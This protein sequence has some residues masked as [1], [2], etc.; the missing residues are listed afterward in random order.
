VSE[1]KNKEIKM[2]TQ[3]QVNTLADPIIISKQEF[4]GAEQ[5]GIRYYYKDAGTGELRPGKQGINIP[6]QFAVQVH[7]ALS[8]VLG[9]WPEAKKKKNQIKGKTKK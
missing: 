1:F 4:R 5:I 2:A 7:A 3:V 9:M 6:V 8:E